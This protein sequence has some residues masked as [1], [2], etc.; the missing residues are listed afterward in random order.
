VQFRDRGRD[1]LGAFRFH[2]QSL[3][4]HFRHGC[5]PHGDNRLACGH[6]LQ[7][8]DAEAFLNAGQTEHIRAAVFGSQGGLREIAHPGDGVL[9]ALLAP[10]AHQTSLFGP[11]AHNANLNSGNP[12]P[13]HRRRLQKQ[14]EPLAWVETAHAEHGE[15]RPG[16]PRGVGFEQGTPGGQVDQLRNNGDLFF[17]PVKLAQPRGGVLARRD[18]RL[19]TANVPRFAGRLQRH[20]P[21]RGA[22]F[23]A[24]LVGDDALDRSNVRDAAFHHPVTVHIEADDGVVAGMGAPPQRLVEPQAAQREVADA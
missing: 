3:R 2:Q 10:Q 12:A 1:R 23:E 18:D 24:H 8:D 20:A 5:H 7:E 13:Q 17:D 14:V 21:P 15:A 6:S 16:L 22:A 19:D 9:D 4:N 11:A